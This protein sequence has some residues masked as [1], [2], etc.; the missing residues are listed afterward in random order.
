[1]N[2]NEYGIIGLLHFIHCLYYSMEYYM[3]DKIQKYSNTNC[4]IL[5][6]KL[7][8]NDKLT[9]SL[10]HF[11]IRKINLSSISTT[12]SCRCEEQE[13]KYDCTEFHHTLEM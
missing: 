4:N 2:T 6:S 11:T 1:M 8:R 9:C 7:F 5:L 13:R 12:C 10:S 3:M